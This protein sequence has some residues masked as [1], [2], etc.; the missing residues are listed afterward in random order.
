MSAHFSPIMMTGALVLPEGMLGYYRAVGSRCITPVSA[1][2]IIRRPSSRQSPGLLDH[3]R[4][5]L[6]D[7]D[8]G[9]VGVA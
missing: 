9:R 6:S 1:D 7:H 2:G 5:L 8:G 3:V 4:A